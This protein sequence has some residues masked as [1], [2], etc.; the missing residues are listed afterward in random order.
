MTKRKRLRRL[1]NPTE[2]SPE[3]SHQMKGEL[4][5]R[6]CGT[7][8]M[9]MMDAALAI[10]GGTIANRKP[11]IDGLWNT[12]IHK[13]SRKDLITN[14]K[15]SPKMTKAIPDIVNKTIREYE[16]NE[17]NMIR[18]VSV[19]YSGGLMSKLKYQRTRYIISFDDEESNS[20]TKIENQ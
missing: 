2:L 9:E 14:V 17:A 18:S 8:R 12:F 20:R 1:R 11:A 16:K 10:N 19:L 13:V 5:I 7:R 15:T 6:S 3:N 4:Q